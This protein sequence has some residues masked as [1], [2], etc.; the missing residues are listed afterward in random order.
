MSSCSLAVTIVDMLTA[1]IKNVIDALE[2]VVTRIQK[3]E[4]SVYVT[5]HAGSAIGSTSLDFIDPEH[6]DSIESP[7][8]SRGLF[9]LAERNSLH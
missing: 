4:S 5:R 8:Y 9:L 6:C 7:R 2:S 3:S 1:V